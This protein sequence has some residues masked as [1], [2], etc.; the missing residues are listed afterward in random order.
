M[1]KVAANGG[2]DPI[3]DATATETELRVDVASQP[4]DK[5][6]STCDIEALLEK[7]ARALGKKRMLANAQELAFN[8]AREGGETYDS[9]GTVTIDKEITFEAPGRV[10]VLVR[11]LRVNLD[12]LLSDKIAQP[13]LEIAS[14]PVLAAIVNLITTERAGFS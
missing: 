9:K 12:K 3:E 14:H 13:S 5:T 10:A 8:L 11:E 2:S 7:V 4:G 6:A 1:A